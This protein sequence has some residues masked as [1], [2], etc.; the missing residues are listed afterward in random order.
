MSFGDVVKA[1]G[2]DD[3]TSR[4]YDSYEDGWMWGSSGFDDDVDTQPYG[5]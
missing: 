5:F 2:D 4:V 3:K 1:L